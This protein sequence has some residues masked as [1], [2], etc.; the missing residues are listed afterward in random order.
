MK[1]D[2]NMMHPILIRF[3]FYLFINQSC[4]VRVC[5]AW[6]QTLPYLRRSLHETTANSTASISSMKFFLW[7]QSYA[8]YGAR[9]KLILI[10]AKSNN[11]TVK[12]CEKMKLSNNKKS[13]TM[14][15]HIMTKTCI[16]RL[17][18]LFSTGQWIA[19][20]LMNVFKNGMFK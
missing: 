3:I 17:K 7:Y 5:Y 4:I 2:E 19:Q 13:K 6:H 1:V 14:N 20:L 16:F 8:I 18:K 15:C 9:E 10:R 11:S 12:R